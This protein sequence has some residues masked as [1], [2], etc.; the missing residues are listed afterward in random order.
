MHVKIL[1][2]L[3]IPQIKLYNEVYNIYVILQVTHSEISSNQSHEMPFPDLLP[4]IDD[5]VVTCN[6][7]VIL[8]AMDGN[9]GPFIV[10][11]LHQIHVGEGAAGTM[12][13]LKAGY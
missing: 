10:R 3:H 11:Q 1:L 7:V 12:E 13:T 9:K 5:N 8:V 6:M 2:Y 4:M